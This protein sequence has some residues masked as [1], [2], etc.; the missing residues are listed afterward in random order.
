MTYIAHLDYKVVQERRGYF[1]DFQL[2]IVPNFVLDGTNTALDGP[3]YSATVLSSFD[4][5]DFRSAIQETDLFGSWTELCPLNKVHCSDQ[6]LKGKISAPQLMLYPNPA[7]TYTEVRFAAEV[8]GEA[9]VSILDK[10]TGKVYLQQKMKIAQKG[11]QTFTIAT[12]GLRENVYTVKVVMKDKV[13]YG[14]L[15]VR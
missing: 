2:Q 8:T 15:V 1:D 5:L 9:V 3:D 6:Q 4:E 10:V 11:P 7:S 12:K 13:L 14:Q